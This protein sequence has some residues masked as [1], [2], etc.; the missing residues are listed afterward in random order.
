MHKCENNRQEN[1][2]KSKFKG[3]GRDRSAGCVT[4]LGDALREAGLETWTTEA[5]KRPTGF[6][7]WLLEKLGKTETRENQVLLVHIPELGAGFKISTADIDEVRYKK[8]TDRLYRAVRQLGPTEISYCLTA[9]DRAEKALESFRSRSKQPI[10]V[11]SANIPE[12]QEHSLAEGAEPPQELEE[13]FWRTDT[14]ISPVAY[15]VGLILLRNKLGE[16]S[17]FVWFPQRGDLILEIPAESL[18]ASALEILFADHGKLAPDQGLTEVRYCFFEQNFK[19]ARE[20]NDYRM[21]VMKLLGLAE[22]PI[23]SQG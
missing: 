13:I 17:C 5:V 7:R 19:H 21:H 1:L 6:V 11:S 23:P 12:F 20:Q 14:C 8:E 22:Q 15:L 16:K 3:A 10:E 9:S 2:A 4:S 18:S